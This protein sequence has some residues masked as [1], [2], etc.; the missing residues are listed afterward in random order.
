MKSL[1]K[2]KTTEVSQDIE[3]SGFDSVSYEFQRVSVSVS[4]GIIRIGKTVKTKT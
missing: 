3:K 2:S 4:A 1:L